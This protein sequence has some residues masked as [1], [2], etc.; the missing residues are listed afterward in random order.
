MRRYI[1]SQMG[2][3]Q[4]YPNLEVLI[5][6]LREMDGTALDCDELLITI[7]DMTDE[8]YNM[9]PEFEGV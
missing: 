5:S 4:T 1:V 7:K 3:C 2:V 6:D 9:L 8:E